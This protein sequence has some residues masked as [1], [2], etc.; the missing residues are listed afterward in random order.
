MKSTDSRKARLPYNDDD[1]QPVMVPR[2]DKGL[3]AMPPERVQRL[4]EYLIKE[5]ADLRKVKHLECF[6]SPVRPAPTRFAA[7]VAQT[8]CSL[9]KGFCCRKGDDDAFLD[10]RTLAR[11][12]LAR[13][14]MTERAL[15]RLYLERV[16]PVAYRDSCIFH[17]SRGCTL[18]RSMRAD[19]CNSY[20]CGGL[21]TFRKSRDPETP[22]VIIAGEGEKMRTSPVLMP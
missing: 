21:G 5:L 7:R 11:V 2:N 9:C 6:A 4:R 22:T 14:G 17:G 15:L 18:D 13:P 1:S 10:D 3:V 8:A 16:P 19:V 12:R 20:F